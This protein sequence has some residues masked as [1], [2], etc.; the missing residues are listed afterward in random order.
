MILSHSRNSW[1]SNIALKISL[2]RSRSQTYKN[3]RSDHEQNHDL[4]ALSCPEL[5]IWYAVSVFNS[6][7]KV[8][9]K[10]FFIHISSPNIGY[11]KFLSW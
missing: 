5:D 3:Q 7:A 6:N 11:H 9:Q 10:N 2:V 4:E 1:K 8:K